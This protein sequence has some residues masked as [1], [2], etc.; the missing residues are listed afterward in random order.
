MADFFID[1]K[2]LLN[3]YKI[4][5]NSDEILTLTEKSC[6]IFLNSTKRGENNAEKNVKFKD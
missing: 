6:I 4:S 1:C 2:T 3:C 5:E